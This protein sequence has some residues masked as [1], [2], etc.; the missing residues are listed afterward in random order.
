MLGPTQTWPFL[1]GCWARTSHH[2]PSHPYVFQAPPLRLRLL[3]ISGLQKEQRRED[4]PCFCLKQLA[5]ILVTLNS[6]CQGCHEG[7]EYSVF[8]AQSLGK[9]EIDRCRAR[10]GLPGFFSCGLY[11]LL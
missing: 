9:R 10:P 4:G 11:V 7:H 3:E 6:L 1:Y 8:S 5:G 2:V